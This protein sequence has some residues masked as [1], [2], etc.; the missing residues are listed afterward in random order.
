MHWRLISSETQDFPRYSYLDALVGLSV[1]WL[2]LLLV[3]VGVDGDDT[4]VWVA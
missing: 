4:Q 3:S 1:L 2:G